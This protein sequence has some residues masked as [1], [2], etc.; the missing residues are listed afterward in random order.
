MQ[1]RHIIQP[2]VDRTR[3]HFC[4]ERSAG[5]IRGNGR[6]KQ[7]GRHDRWTFIDD[8]SGNLIG[9]A[10]VAEQN[11]VTGP[12]R[13]QPRKPQVQLLACIFELV[14]MWLVTGIKAVPVTGIQ[15]Q[16]DGKRVFPVFGEDRLHR[17]HDFHILVPQRSVQH[18]DHVLSNVASPCQH[19]I[20]I[21]NQA[22]VIHRDLISQ[23]QRYAN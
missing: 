16:I 21:Q 10:R 3:C 9:A 17:L 2:V 14:S 11:D 4:R 19:E 1:E 5:R 18:Q 12:L 20:A 15:A 23:C 7:D 6:C 22:A 8:V 13:I